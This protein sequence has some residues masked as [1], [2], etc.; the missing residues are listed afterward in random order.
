[1]K[2]FEFPTTKEQKRL[3]ASSTFNFILGLIKCVAALL[4]SSKLFAISGAYSFALC[5]VR[6]PFLPQKESK[7]WLP[8]SC[9]LSVLFTI[10]GVICLLY[11]VHIILTGETILYSKVST[12]L[13]GVCAIVKLGTSVYSLTMARESYIEKNFVMKLT[14]AADGLISLVLTQSAILTLNNVAGAAFYNGLFGVTVGGCIVL[15]SIFLFIHLARKEANT[16]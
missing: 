7:E 8:A 12:Y 5:F 15:I 14:N 3:F 6:V 13:L 16:K 10:L 11:S 2:R 9:R 1:M 4:S